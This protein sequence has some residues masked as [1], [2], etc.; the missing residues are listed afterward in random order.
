MESIKEEF[1]IPRE[2]TKKYRMQVGGKVAAT[3][4]GFVCGFVAGAICAG[5]IGYVKIYQLLNQ[6]VEVQMLK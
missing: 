4:T 6:I 2:K 5:M 3:L 1:L